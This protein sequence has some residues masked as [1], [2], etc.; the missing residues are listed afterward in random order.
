MSELASICDLV[1]PLDTLVLG[2]QALIEPKGYSDVNLFQ[3]S[4]LYS[5]ALDSLINPVYSQKHDLHS[6][7]PQLVY[8]Q[9]PNLVTL[10][11]QAPYPFKDDSRAHFLQD[12]SAEVLG[13]QEFYMSFNSG[14]KELKRKPIR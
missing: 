14:L 13:K 9:T 4:G 3:K 1:I 5:L 6:L 2:G 7:L 11:M 10:Q 8:S 12:L